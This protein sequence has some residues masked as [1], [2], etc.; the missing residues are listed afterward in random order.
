MKKRRKG[1]LREFER[2]GY[3]KSSEEYREE[4]RQNAARA[5]RKRKVRINKGRIALT[6]IVLMLIAVVGVS[7]K[8][9]F[10]LRAEQREL[11]QRQK[12]LN[13]EKA[14]LQEELKNVN[15]LDYIEEQARNQLKLIKPG[16]ILY[17]LENEGEDISD[18]N[19]EQEDD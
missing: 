2:E 1:R 15:D 10:D 3:G 19:Q 7:I 17:I 8:N 11:A 9:V 4:R 12:E 6:V 16:E 13:D 14:A 18:D 5:P